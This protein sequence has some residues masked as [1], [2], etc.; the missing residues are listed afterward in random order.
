ML[1]ANN[2]IGLMA[3][4]CVYVLRLAEKLNVE[5]YKSQHEPTK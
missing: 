5:K 4:F 2:S 3:N 1:P